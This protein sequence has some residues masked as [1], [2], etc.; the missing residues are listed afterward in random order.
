MT[1]PDCKGSGRIVLFTSSK[2]CAKCGGSGKGVEIIPLKASPSDLAFMEVQNRTREEIVSIFNL[3]MK[4]NDI[5][6]GSGTPALGAPYPTNT[7]ASIVRMEWSGN[8]VVPV[9][10]KFTFDANGKVLGVSDPLI[11]KPL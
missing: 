4:V 10:R 8:G 11:G 6:F 5:Q 7:S 1:C 3:P 2:P 9:L